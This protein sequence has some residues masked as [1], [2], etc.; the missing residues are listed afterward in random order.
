MWLEENGSYST[1]ASLHGVV[2]YM[3]QIR[4]WAIQQS[5][6]YTTYKNIVLN[7]S[8]NQMSMSKDVI[9]SILTFAGVNQASGSYT[10]DGA[11]F[12]SGDT[13]VDL[14]SCKTYTA[15]SAGE[16]TADVGA[17]AMVVMMTASFLAGSTMCGY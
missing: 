5:S 11:G 12:S 6:T 3:N 8:D 4:N 17:G 13:V 1:S 16:V 15:S 9:R 14:I 2:A 10:T 7:Y